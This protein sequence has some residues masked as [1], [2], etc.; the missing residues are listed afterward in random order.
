[1]FLLF[2]ACL[3]I[4]VDGIG[5]QLKL[6]QPTLPDF[7]NEVRIINLQIGES[8]LD[9]HVMKQPDGVGVTVKN[10]KNGPSVVCL[11]A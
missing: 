7:L 6:V 4:Q 3:G 2:Q 10:A 5:K 11:C 8:S 9:I 1:M